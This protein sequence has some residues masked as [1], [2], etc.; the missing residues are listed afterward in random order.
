MYDEE[1]G[2]RI[3]R[4]LGLA[5][6]D[7][8]ITEFDG[9]PALVVER[10]DREDGAGDS[11]PQR[12]HQEDFNQVL[13]TQGDQKYQRYGGKASFL[14]VARELTT[15]G[16][17]RSVRRLARMTVLSAA[18]GNLDLHAK[19]LALLHPRDGS[20]QLAP[21]YDVVPQ[22]HLPNDGELAL[23]VD[24]VYRHAAITRAHLVA[25]IHSWGVRD[26]DHVVDESL[27]AVLETVSVETPD[28][29]AHPGLADDIVR[30]ATNLRAGREA[31]HH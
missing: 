12:I 26:A 4:A 13:G 18:I 16:D 15:L 17:R 30:F 5:D 6:V 2:A 22:A 28:P 8:R 3:A 29:R 27:A 24:R 14:R 19:N 7:T 1:Y 25:E 9:V 21:A 11:P 31:G 10:Y 23:A 20:V